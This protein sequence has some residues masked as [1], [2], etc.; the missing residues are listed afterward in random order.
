VS[1]DVVVLVNLPRRSQDNTPSTTDKVLATFRADSS[2]AREPTNASPGEANVTLRG[3][4]PL[5]MQLRPQVRLVEGRWFV[6]GK[7]EAVVSARV[8]QRFAHCG[9]GQTI[10]TGGNELAIVGWFD[11]SNTAFDSEI[12]MDADEARSLFDRNNYSSVLLRVRNTNE[13]PAL[14][15]RIEGDK[16]APLRA[17]PEIAYYSAQTRTA[18]P[19][20]ILG[21]FLATT[22]SIG[23]IFAAMNTMYASVGSRTR[24]IGTLRVLGFRRRSVMLGF[25]IEGIILA[26]V[27]GV[28]GCL[29]ALPMHGASTGTLSFDS[30][31]EVVFQFRITPLLVA[32]G[33]LFAVLVGF[34]GSVLPAARAARLPVISALKAV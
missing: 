19:I 15:A 4:T 16:R 24:E 26:F 7:R 17:E 27:G 25:I 20:R 29:L 28:L 5:G 34:V 33:M 6:P 21:G 11:A 8:A 1:A 14:I 13:M 2:A 30:F 32:E 3:I 31:S 22:M 9:V 18:G 10:R 12:W 23:A